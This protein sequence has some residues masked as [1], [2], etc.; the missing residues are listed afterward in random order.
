MTVVVVVTRV[1]I[2]PAVI[3][4]LTLCLKM[5]ASVSGDKITV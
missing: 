5:I 2:V 1:D 3:T 4:E